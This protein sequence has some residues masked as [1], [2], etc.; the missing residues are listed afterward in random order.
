MFTQSSI[1]YCLIT[2]PGDFEPRTNF[3]VTIPA[4][5]M[6]VFVEVV[7][8]DDDIVED[9]ESFSAVLS[10]PV[11]ETLVEIGTNSQALAEIVDNDRKF[12]CH[13]VM[14]MSKSLKQTIPTFCIEQNLQSSWRTGCTL[15]LRM[16]CLWKSVL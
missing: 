12:K 9:G 6:E 13:F 3:L 8:T 15:Y 14:S 2:G 1:A 4:N 7:V 10:V 11:G 16:R 5:Q